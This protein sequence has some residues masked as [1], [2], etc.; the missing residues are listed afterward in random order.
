VKIPAIVGPYRE[1]IPA[2]PEGAPGP[3]F[4]NDHCFVHGDDG[5]WHCFGINDPLL[6]DKE[7]MYEEHP[8]LLHA[9]APELHGPWIR[10]PWALDDSRGERYLGA[11]FVVKHAGAWLMLF[12]AKHGG[13][14][15]LELARS[16]D[17]FHWKR[18][19]TPIV[20]DLP[21]M[22]RDPCVA[23]DAKTGDYLLYLCVP[24]GAVSLVTVSRTTDFRTFSPA[25][26][27]LSLAD[28]CPWA[29]LESPFAVPY[30]GRWY[31][32][33][34][35]SMH[36]YHETPV[37]A[38]NDPERFD[39]GDQVATLHAHAAEIVDAGGAWFVSTCGPEDRRLNNRHGIELAPLRWLEADPGAS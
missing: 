14:R 4:T 22:R 19:R 37:L 15:G 38:S 21:H 17:L 31:L 10:H 18:E 20:T 23:V 35:H 8:Y 28:G 2:I 34:T 16:E 3:W 1:I 25:K 32:F 36:H 5:R 29:S 27:V 33:F 9:S 7:R 24:R 11:P 26:V 30:D 6:D 12:E 39:W 13:R